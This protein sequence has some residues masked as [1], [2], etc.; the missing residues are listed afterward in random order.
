MPVIQG[1]TSRGAHVRALHYLLCEM[2]AERLGAPPSVNG[3]VALRDHIVALEK[4][5]PT[6]LGNSRTEL[7]LAHYFDEETTDASRTNG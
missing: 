7:D 3:T 6:E 1:R 4:A 2:L 5:Y